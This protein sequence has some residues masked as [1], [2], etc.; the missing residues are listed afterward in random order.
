MDPSRLKSE[1]PFGCM[2]SQR[3]LSQPTDDSTACA[4]HF[5]HNANYRLS[6]PPVPAPGPSLLDDNE[7]DLLDT[8]FNGVGSET[9]NYDFFSTSAD[10][11]PNR[12]SW[13]DIP[14]AF[15]GTSSSF[16]PQAPRISQSAPPPP[17][18]VQQSNSHTMSADPYALSPTSLEPTQD[19]LAAAA[20]LHHG[21][22]GL[23]G[24]GV[25]GTYKQDYDP[26]LSGM[27]SSGVSP[28]DTMASSP[29]RP[30]VVYPTQPTSS[31]SYIFGNNAGPSLHP[32]PPRTLRFGS[33]TS[34]N[35]VPG[36]MVATS[37]LEMEA[38][39]RSQMSAMDAFFQ[40]IDASSTAENT[41]PSS[42]ITQ[43]SQPYLGTT[44]NEQTVDADDRPRK[45]RKSKVEVAFKD[46]DEDY[47]DTEPSVQKTNGHGKRRSIARAKDSPTQSS[48]PGHKRRK[49][50][51][52]GQS[53]AMLKAGRENLTED[54]KRENHIKSEQKRRQQIK[55]GFEDLHELVPA[56]RAG[57]FSKSAV[58]TMAADWLEELLQG[59]AEL[60]QKIANIKEE[61][62]RSNG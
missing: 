18:P 45:R 15:M 42:P 12:H 24:M 13:T 44:S 27:T 32:A 31:A 34:F 58:L 55:E 11:T 8:F 37:Q 16:G 61:R 51:T 1:M 29:V 52:I 30:L 39:E 54:Q 40:A 2:Y 10:Q 3:P 53:S 14:P 7:S 59:N 43:Q 28:Y 60:R 62:R 9:L 20:L 19:V 21:S 50:S 46:E 17:P 5:E 23:R 38:A 35:A 41:R 47:E 4:D 36:M 57:G 48:A 25:T 6:T 56:L 22:N 49:S 26:V 33:D